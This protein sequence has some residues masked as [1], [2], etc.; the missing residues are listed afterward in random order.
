MFS[1]AYLRAEHKNSLIKIH[2]NGVFT[3]LHRAFLSIF[4]FLMSK[5]QKPLTFEH[6]L[7][8]L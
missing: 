1:I 2:F 7:C 4:T 5:V 3:N 6:F 8:I